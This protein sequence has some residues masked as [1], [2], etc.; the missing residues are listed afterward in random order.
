MSTT[1]PIITDELNFDFKKIH[2]LFNN[3]IHNFHSPQNTSSTNSIQIP[4]MGA[5]NME[6]IVIYTVL[7][8]LSS[9]GNT[10][11][12]IALLFMNKNN[13]S[14]FKNSRSRIRLILMNLCIA[15]LMV[16]Y[17]LLPLEIIWAMTNSW[18]AGETMCKLMMFLRTFGLYLSSFVIITI[19][20]GKLN[21]DLDTKGY[22]LY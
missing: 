18:L 15:D 5:K 17:I 20:I 4:I 1:F 7:F 10:T 19:T 14:N 9:I 6:K 3:S 2:H 22:Q 16:T 21:I 13:N 8:F 12:F 11:S